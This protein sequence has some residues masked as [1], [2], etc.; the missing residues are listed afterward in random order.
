M[1]L[2]LTNSRLV[3]NVERTVVFSPEFWRQFILESVPNIIQV[4]VATQIAKMGHGWWRKSPTVRNTFFWSDSQTCKFFFLSELT[5]S[6]TITGL[7]TYVSR[8][9]SLSTAVSRSGIPCPVQSTRMAFLAVELIERE[10]T[11]CSFLWVHF[12]FSFILL[13]HKGS[14]RDVY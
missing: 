10:K 11:V 1:G 12:F 2:A 8:G 6:M 9:K 13:T 3:I 14:H 5:R 4:C 7:N